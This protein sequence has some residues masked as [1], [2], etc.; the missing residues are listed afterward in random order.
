[1]KFL[2]CLLTLMG[3][4]S[5][6]QAYMLPTKIILQKTAENSGFGVYSME[7]EVQFQNGA[8]IL[9]LREN[10]LIEND[11]TM[12]VTVTGTKDL[13]SQ[14]RMQFLYAGGQ[15]YEFNGSSRSG[16]KMPED[17]FERFLNFRS[18]D[19]FAN[20]LV[21]LRLIPA[22]AMSKKIPKNG[23]E[24]KNEAEPFV[25]YSRVGGVVAY[26]F[27]EPTAP[28]KETADPGVWI[29]QD[30]F[31]V[32][33]VRLSSQAEMTADNYTQFAKGLNYP[34]QRTIR[35]GTHSANIRLISA[36][37]KPGNSSALF[38]ANSLDITPR[39]EGLNNIPAK[40]AILEF[41]SRFR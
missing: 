31:V 30:Q 26:A 19:S 40:D 39:T 8:E 14:I 29:E 13:Q 27:G 37:A 36:S 1:M 11:R 18:A 10:W 32:R 3:C 16:K 25:R 28:G 22:S 20:A 2:F 34:R 15:R 23:N 24:F 9:S 6:S 4:A 38:Q 35:W 33:K 21:N 12:R 5:L 41:Y 7:Q 17:F